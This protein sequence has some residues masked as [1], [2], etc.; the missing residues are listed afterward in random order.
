MTLDGFLTFLGL[1][2][3]VFA[4]IPPV[5]RLRIRLQLVPQAF[6]AAAAL[7]LALYFEFFQ[8]LA[9]PCLPAFRIVCDGL[10]IQPGGAFTPAMAAFLV[11]LVWMLLA[12]LVAICLPPS[13]RSIRG[14]ADLVEQLFHQQRYGEAVDF[15]LPHVRFLERAQNRKLW[16]QKLK[17]RFTGERIPDLEEW[18][19]NPERAEK[20]RR[21]LAPFRLLS[22][23][24]PEGGHAQEHAERI[25]NSLYLSRQFMDYAALQRPSVTAVLLTLDAHQ[26]F[27]FSNR[28]LASLASSQGSRLYEEIERNAKYEG[29]GDNLVVGHNF[30]LRAYFLDASVAETLAAWKPVG[31][32]VLDYIRSDDPAVRAQLHGKSDGFD[33]RRWRDPIAFAIAYFDLM[34]RSAFSQ[35]I[36]DHMWLA[37]LDHFVDEL[38]GVYDATG[39]DIDQDDEFPTWNAHLIY[40]CINTLG[41]WVQFI[42]EAPAGSVHQSFPE[43]LHQ[44]SAGIPANAA[45]CLGTCLYH[46]L[47]S[48]R[49]GDTFARYMVECVLRDIRYLV[50]PGDAAARK[51]L[52]RSIVTGGG[53]DNAHDYGDRLAYLLGGIDCILLNDVPDFLDAARVAHPL[54]DFPE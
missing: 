4:I 17:D 33:Q 12:C 21:W 36:K 48:D 42:R 30:I 31:D 11:V 44:G 29:V 40:E 6:L 51:F 26:R 20:K 45:R 53:R 10:V 2:A 47:R 15:V 5:A 46:V 1:A 18:L 28:L 16:N 54:A 22:R 34:I 37:Y 35:D 7:V 50:Q 27:D 38:V 23:G 13:Q 32:F 19:S 41:H 14:M 39:P 43:S 9:L 25:L 52:I 49:V 8:F 24:I 3:A